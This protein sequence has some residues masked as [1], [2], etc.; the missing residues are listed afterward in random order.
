MLNGKS[1]LME[2]EPLSSSWVT[3][4]LS[5][6]LNHITSVTFLSMTYECAKR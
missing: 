4:T 6:A 1:R 2:A 3:S 5:S